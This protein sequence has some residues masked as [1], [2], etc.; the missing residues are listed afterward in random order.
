MKIKKKTKK[1][2]KM[3]QFSLYLFCLFLFVVSI[4]ADSLWLLDQIT[5]PDGPSILNF[6]LSQVTNHSF[7]IGYAGSG[8]GTQ[9]N[10]SI[11]TGIWVNCWLDQ[12]C[13]ISSGCEYGVEYNLVLMTQD[14]S[15]ECIQNVTSYTLTFYDVIIPD[16]APPLE[17]NYYAPTIYYYNV[18]YL[19][20]NL[21]SIFPTGPFDFINLNSI[22]LSKSYYSQMVVISN[23]YTDIN[24]TRYWQVNYKSELNL[25]GNRQFDIFDLDLYINNYN[26]WSIQFNVYIIPPLNGIYNINS[27][28][29][30]YLIT[31]LNRVILNRECLIGIN[32]NQTYRQYYW[33]DLQT[34]VINDITND[35]SYF[36]GTLDYFDDAH[37]SYD[38]KCNILSCNI[39]HD[40]TIDGK[41]SISVFRTNDS[42]NILNSDS[43]IIYEPITFNS[44]SK[45]IYIENSVI[46]NENVNNSM[47]SGTL[48]RIH[49]VNSYSLFA[50]LSHVTISSIG[51]PCLYV[52]Y[53]FVEY[54]YECYID[55][56]N[57]TGN[58][59][60]IYDWNFVLLDNGY[61]Y[62]N[63]LIQPF[64]GP[65]IYCTSI[66]YCDAGVGYN[67]ENAMLEL[68]C[69]VNLLTEFSYDGNSPNP[70]TEYH[71]ISS[72]YRLVVD[73]C[74][75]PISINYTFGGFS[76]V[77]LP[78]FSIINNITDIDFMYTL[79]MD[80]VNY[81]WFYLQINSIY[82]DNVVDLQFSL[83]DD[84]NVW[85]GI[86]HFTYQQTDELLYTIIIDQL[87]PNLDYFYASLQLY[88]LANQNVNA[89]STNIIA[90]YMRQYQYI[91]LN[92]TNANNTDAKQNFT[93]T[94]LN[95]VSDDHLIIFAGTDT[96]MTFTF[97]YSFVLPPYQDEDTKLVS[98]LVFHSLIP[99]Y[100]QINVICSPISLPIG[101]NFTGD[102][103]VNCVIQSPK[104]LTLYLPNIQ[105]ISN[106][107]I[108]DLNV[109]FYFIQ[110]FQ[111][112][113]VYRLPNVLNQIN[114]FSIRTTSFL[115][116]SGKILNIFNNIG[117]VFYY[118]GLASQVIDS[119]LV[120]EIDGMAYFR[121][122]SL[123]TTYSTTFSSNS[124]FSFS[125]NRLS[126][127]VNIDYGTIDNLVSLQGNVHLFYSPVQQIS[128]DIFEYWLIPSL[129]YIFSAGL[130]HESSMIP[131][132]P[133][134]FYPVDE[135]IQVN[136]TC[137]YGDFF[138][139][140]QYC[141]MKS[142]NQ[143]SS[144]LV[145]FNFTLFNSSG[146]ILNLIVPPMDIE[147]IDY[148]PKQAY[149]YELVTVIFNCT[150]CDQ[151]TLIEIANITCVI[152]NPLSNPGTYDQ[153][154]AGL[155]LICTFNTSNTDPGNYTVVIN[156]GNSKSPG[157]FTILGEIPITTTTTTATS[158]TTTTIT[159]TTEIPTTTITTTTL[160]P[161]TTTIEPTTTITTTTTLEPT[162]T[163]LEPT[164]TVTTTTT[165]TIEPTT[166]TLEPT[167]TITTTTTTIEPTTTTAQ[168]TT[169][170]TETTT[171]ATTTTTTAQ[172]TTTE[173]ITTTTTTQPTTT[174]TQSTTGTTTTGHITTTTTTTAGPTTTSTPTT[175]SIP[176][177]TIPFAENNGN[178]NPLTI[179]VSITIFFWIIIVVI[180][181]SVFMI[182]YYYYGPYRGANGKNN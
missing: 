47:M 42:V 100:P 1:T 178:S 133:S 91:P 161:T 67:I 6:Y 7:A 98:T 117:G 55:T 150:Y 137:S 147:I 61:Y 105:I 31:E 152:L 30:E 93:I 56:S 122:Y 29:G 85:N 16:V 114:V 25:L 83:T 53:S 103:L 156:S 88:A 51:L 22:L 175:T 64:S 151:L 166:T 153:Q 35:C 144:G 107:Y 176:T 62:I 139:L 95:G 134:M 129:Q 39:N 68:P 92:I 10:C 155:E 143:N 28:G 48:V 8:N 159:T 23:E 169:T 102:F 109:T 34:M 81:G 75:V 168:P 80:Q 54:Y 124:F 112:Y 130:P 108:F 128:S 15:I 46:S 120:Y 158:T 73:I 43:P 142:L 84:V 145:S 74:D 165:T 106:Q 21:I 111:I 90:K 99:F 12:P 177:A 125:L 126:E 4:K 96:A 119:E 45:A 63:L 24:G 58:A 18:T 69:G 94:E 160:E 170:T 37:S 132:S 5:P 172:P 2:K 97:T 157:N 163:T 50:T 101:I 154:M 11:Q 82:V 182:Y 136:F 49:G 3:K 59:M 162:T 89:F 167:T 127:K 87:P 52:N 38:R 115:V 9:F 121:V 57:Y 116:D 70:I 76:Q 138:Y 40:L 86:N 26:M 181:L 174:T 149:Q 118:N 17:L 41:L 113:S 33:T 32:P 104:T 20:G 135:N 36:T 77:T 164:T 65:A 13:S 19:L 141:S 60:L 171:T 110:P 180:F 27:F 146:T 123:S 131:I 72:K 173:T 66:N 148:E 78:C 140:V 79:S 44:A 14:N 179:T 71:P